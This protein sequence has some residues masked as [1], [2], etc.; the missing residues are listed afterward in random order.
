MYDFQV[1]DDVN[2]TIDILGS[3]GKRERPWYS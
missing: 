1:V 2:T 3:L